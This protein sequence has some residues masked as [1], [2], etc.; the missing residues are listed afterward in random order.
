M[1]ARMGVFFIW[2][3]AAMT[4]LFVLS[5]IARSPYLP[6]LVYG[7]L[8]L[9]LGIIFRVRGA[10]APEANDTR[11]RSIRRKKRTPPDDKEQQ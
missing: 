3:G 6:L 10:T 8:L 1:I 11:F 7:L 9:I 4:F 2:I 5:D